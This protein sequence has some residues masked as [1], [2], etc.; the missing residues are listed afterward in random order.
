MW[1]AL[2]IDADTIPLDDRDNVEV[3]G[4][5]TAFTSLTD[6]AIDGIAVDARG[7]TFEGGAAGL[8]PGA[9]VEVKGSLRGGVLL[10]TK[11]EFED[12]EGDGA[13]FVLNGAIQSVDPT[14]MR[15]VVR[16]VTVVWSVTT[17][18]DNGS[19]VDLVVGASVEVRG[20]LS[21]DRLTIDATLIHVVR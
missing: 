5:I 16:G 8:A 15:F 4:R 14:A 3:E 17:R 21:S 9:K 11:V 7:A 13:S 6:F 19:D 2:S 20:R 1:V 12:D 18:F 10:A